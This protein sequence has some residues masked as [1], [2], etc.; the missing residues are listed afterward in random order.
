MKERI[1]TRISPDLLDTI[2]RSFKFRHGKGVAEWLKNSLDAYLR[3]VAQGRES[4]S[5]GW[6]VLLWIMNGDKGKRGPNLAVIDFSGASFDQLDQF[7]L[8]WGDT[9]AATLGGTARPGGLTGGHG[10]GGKFYMREMWKHGARFL[11]WKDG[12]LSSL[13]VDKV[14]PGSTGYW[15][16][17]SQRVRD[18]RHA[19]RAAFP[20]EDGL[21]SPNDLL[22]HLN[23]LDPDLIRELDQEARGLSVVLGRTAKQVLS[24][25]DLVR[26][27]K[28]DSQRLVDAILA[29][30]QAR[31]PIRELYVHV[32]IDAGQSRR[33]KAENVVD[34]PE[35]PPRT[36]ELSG[37]LINRDQSTIGRLT[38]RKASERLVGK[39]KDRNGVVVLDQQANPVGWYP[40]SELAVP[41]VPARR[42]LHGDVQLD[43]PGLADI[44]HND[45]ERLIPG[46]QTVGILSGIAKAFTQRIE[47]I[48]EAERRQGENTRLESAVLLNDSLNEH[49]RRFLQKLESEVFTD[50][51]E[52]PGG[53]GTGPAESG[54]GRSGNGNGSGDRNGAGDEKGKG[55]ADSANGGNRK[56]RRPKF[57]QVLLS[58]VDADP[59][60]LSGESK[61]LSKMDPPLY[62]DDE[63]RRF[64]IWW[65]NASHPFAAIALEHGGARGKVF[66]SHQLFMFRDV[67]QR[68]AMRMLQRREAE[69][70]LDRLETELDEI[71]NKFL[72]D[73]PIDVVELFVNGESGEQDGE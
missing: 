61:R 43:F 38:V 60:K 6:P 67:V 46:E 15:E 17:K 62:Q 55:D 9:T 18:W 39:L 31:R 25:N 1:G 27:K 69:M 42:F 5:G 53:G 23:R 37:N 48:E 66:R 52:D 64:N 28:W 59:T 63:D 45:R 2:G 10:N 24:S 12:R 7:F 49:A 50:F 3:S 54:N 32:V 70:A 20:E 26:G 30:P 19:L 8:H 36:I 4:R 13:V 57:P 33:L 14:E 73:L 65:I 72:G 40:M 51:V 21:M 68:E 71:S 16:R 22:A 41:L 35:W 29:S 34:D 47:E 58:G 56:H 11:T 44:V